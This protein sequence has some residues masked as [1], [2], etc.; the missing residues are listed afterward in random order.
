MASRYTRELG[1]SSPLRTALPEFRPRAG[2]ERL[3][4]LIGE[5]LE[6]GGVLVAEAATG[7]G[8][9][10]AYLVPA[11][12]CGQRVVVTTAT[13]AL[14]GQLLREDLPLARIASGE[15]L[16]AAVVK[17]RANYVCRVQRAFADQRV[18]EAGQPELARIAE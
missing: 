11:A 12:G 16:T 3:A 9:S 17:G 8:K 13:K 2:Q 18:P 5:R 15:P 14:Q 7:I 10:L 1:G 6:R 4:E